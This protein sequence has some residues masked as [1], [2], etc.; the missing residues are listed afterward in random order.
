[1]TK[2]KKKSCI[3]EVQEGENFCKYH[4]SKFEDTIKVTFTVGASIV[5]FV[6]FRNI[7]K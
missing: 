7:K 2:C 4:R 5:G 3:N 1:M 6:L